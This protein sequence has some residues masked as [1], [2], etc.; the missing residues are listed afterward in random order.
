MCLL[1]HVPVWLFL[2]L[3]L[4]VPRTKSEGPIG[5]ARALGKMSR[6]CWKEDRGSCG[7]Q[8]M[9]GKTLKADLPPLPR[10]TMTNYLMEN[11]TRGHIFQMSWSVFTRDS[12]Q[13]VINP[14][15]LKMGVNAPSLLHFLKRCLP[16][17]V[18][19]V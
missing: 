18:V 12:R 9:D 8:R 17:V 16:D 7:K 14:S 3:C 2:D 11:E 6:I 19:S 5:A 15:A 1:S 10:Q 4:C 13:L